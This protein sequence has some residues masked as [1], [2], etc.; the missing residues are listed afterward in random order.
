MVRVSAKDGLLDGRW[1]E[2]ELGRAEPYNI[3][4][5]VPGKAIC[6]QDYPSPATND[7]KSIV[8]ED[9]GAEFLVGRACLHARMH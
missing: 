5:L 6:I 3:A 1:F 8:S 4:S 2:M 7:T 9:F